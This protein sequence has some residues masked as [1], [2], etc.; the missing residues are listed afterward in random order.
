MDELTLLRELDRDIAPPTQEVLDRAFAELAAGIAGGR[1]AGGRHVPLRRGVRR[2]AG[3]VLLA[4]GTLTATAALTAGLV[5]SDV[6]GVAGLR[7]GASAQAAEILHTAATRTISTADPVVGPDQYLR[8]HVKELN[9]GS[10]GGHAWIDSTEHD[11]YIPADRSRTWV[12][13]MSPGRPVQFLT[14][15]SKR[16]ALSRYRQH[17]AARGFTG[18]RAFLGEGGWD[19]RPYNPDG[20]VVSTLPTDPRMLLN[21]LYREGLGAGLNPDQEAFAMIGDLLRSG[22]VPARTRA[23]LYQAAALI[24]GVTTTPGTA[25][26]DGRIGVAIGRTEPTT[27]ERQDLVIDPVS[28][29]LIG[30]RSYSTVARR[31]AGV[32]IPAGTADDVTSVETSVVAHLPAGALDHVSQ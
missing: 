21:R 6:I 24:P 7:P 23:A 28:G 1:L 8:I 19:G 16:F 31:V 2:R 32:V 20:V 11:F 12:H 9:G 30:E 22:V 5:L 3:R 15:G 10:E 26:L 17:M 27:K 25:N 18:P 13:L 29:L 14:P 4:V